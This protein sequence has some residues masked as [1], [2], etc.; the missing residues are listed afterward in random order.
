[1]Y[2]SLFHYFFVYFSVHIIISHA[3]CH[4]YDIVSFALFNKE[5]LNLK[6]KWC[7]LRK[8]LASLL[9]VYILRPFMCINHIK[10]VM[11]GG[12]HTNNLRTWE[13]HTRNLDYST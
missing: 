9:K 12:S 6:K 10:S 5:I 8:S 1:M 3:M 2:V 13:E 11:Y 4:Y 7:N